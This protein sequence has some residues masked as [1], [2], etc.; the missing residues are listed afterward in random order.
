[1]TIK[2]VDMYVHVYVCAY[3]TV[4]RNI[5]YASVCWYVYPVISHKLAGKTEK[6]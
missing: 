2:Y 3:D 6:L 1:M 5:S 4:W